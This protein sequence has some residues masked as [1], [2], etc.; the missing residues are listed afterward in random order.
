MAS[1][2]KLCKC[3]ADVISQTE[4]AYNTHSYL[5]L[6]KN[7]QIRKKIENFKCY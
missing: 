6:L 2:M 7:Y 5:Q 4:V 3:E 1:A